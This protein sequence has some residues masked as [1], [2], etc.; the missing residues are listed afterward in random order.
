MEDQFE[1]TAVRVSMVSIVGNAILATLKLLA[2][3]LAHSGAMISDAVHSAS[4]VLSSVIVIFGVKI[5][6]AMRFGS[7]RS[8]GHRSAS[9]PHLRRQD[10]CG[11]RDYRGCSDYAGGKS[12]HRRAGARR[13]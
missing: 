5:S 10:L 8:I 9:N 3:I 6:V 4:D 11:Y 1:A 13:H 2:G 12:C 7:A